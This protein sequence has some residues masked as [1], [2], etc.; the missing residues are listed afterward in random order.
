M[1]PSVYCN[2]TDNETFSF[3][4]KYLLILTLLI[5]LVLSGCD[6]R[7][8]EESLQKKEATLNE[9]EQ[10]LLLRERTLQLREEELASWK[11]RM[12]ST[13]VADSTAKVDSSLIGTWAVQMTCTETNCPGSAVGDVKTEN[14]EIGYQDRNVIAKAK[15]NNELVRV[16]SGFYTGNTLELLETHET[17]TQATAKM[18]VRLRI[19]NDKQLEGQREIERLAESCKIIYAVTMKKQ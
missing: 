7:Q 17:Q 12:D 10:Q 19:V 2:F 11:Q 16:Y 13:T 4:M 3:R 9:K 1:R 6:I 15:V 14:W 18:V 5:F 8:R